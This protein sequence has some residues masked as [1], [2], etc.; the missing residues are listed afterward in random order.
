MEYNDSVW[1]ASFGLSISSTCSL[2]I[3]RA[4]AAFAPILAFAMLAVML[5]TPAFGASLQSATS[6]SVG[7]NLSGVLVADFNRDG[8]ADVLVIDSPNNGSTNTIHVLL[9]NGDGTFQ[10]TSIDSVAT[11]GLSAVV[12][13]DF[14]GDGILDIAVTDSANNT[15]TVLSGNGNGSFTSQSPMPTGSSPTALAA[16]DL[17]G[18]GKSDLIVANFGSTTLDV[19]LGNGNGTFTAAG[20]VPAASPTFGS[21]GPVGIVTGD[22]DN[23]GKL[24]IA[25][26]LTSNAM[27]MLKG[28][29]NGTFQAAV[30]N[31]IFNFPNP[32]AIAAT[33]FDGDGNLDL[34]ITAGSV[35]LL[36]GRGDLTFQSPVAFKAQ[37]GPSGV[38]VADMNGDAHP[39]I[40]VAD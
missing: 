19:F 33:D 22:F 15:V 9:G 12:S 17:N 14:N 36:R 29:G 37:F 27:S 31:I 4:G 21:F 5:Q 38:V 25:V 35:L 28:N 39:D 24:D 16:A 30:T 23:D 2:Y 8:H 3:R 7:T 20:S 32:N 40:L 34:I 1:F 13:G 18:D 6:Y 26:A 11:S 10:K